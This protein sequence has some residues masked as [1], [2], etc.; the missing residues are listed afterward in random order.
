MSSKTV[1]IRTDAA[2]AFT[3]ERPFF[4]EIRAIY[5]DPD[6]L[7]T[8]DIVITDP[9]HGTTIRTMTGL[10]AED[11]YQPGAPIA[12]FGTLKVAVTGGGD[13]KHGRVRFLLE[14]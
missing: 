2:G 10:S 11:F 5:T 6:T 4:G 9:V 8:P 14:T 3:Y 13:T 1:S 12:V 7:E